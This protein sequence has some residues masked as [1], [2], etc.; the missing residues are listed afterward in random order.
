M[1]DYLVN[2]AFDKV[3]DWQIF[4]SES[5]NNI[6]LYSPSKDVVLSDGYVFDTTIKMIRLFG[7]IKIGVL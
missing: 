2:Y 3:N 4:V 5:N 7:F 6:L 1:S